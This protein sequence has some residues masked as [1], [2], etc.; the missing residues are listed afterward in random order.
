MTLIQAIELIEKYLENPRIRVLRHEV[1]EGREYFALR[2]EIP[3]VG[4]LLEIREFWKENK[5]VA[6]G[7]YLRV[8]DYEEW[9]DNRP[10][11]PEVQTFPHHRHVNGRVEP[12]PDPSLEAFLMRVKELIDR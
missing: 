6:Y 10:H 11:H 9:W 5:L 7:Y 1:S 8:K 2:V 12:L 4:A 3:H